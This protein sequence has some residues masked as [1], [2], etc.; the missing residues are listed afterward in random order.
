MATKLIPGVG[1]VDEDRSGQFL[2]P[3]VGSF[4]DPGTYV[5]A[6]S[7]SMT[8][9]SIA[10]VGQASADFVVTINGTP[11]DTVTVTPNDGNQGGTFNPASVFLSPGVLSATFTYTA[12]SSGTK[13]ISLNNDSSLINP[14]P[15][16]VDCTAD[17]QGQITSV[18][19]NGQKGRIDFTFIENPISGVASFVAAATPNG[20]V[21]QG[22]K[23][24][25]LSPS[26]STGF[27]EFD[28]PPGDYDQQSVTLS[29]SAGDTVITSSTAIKVIGVGGSPQAPGNAPPATV[30]GIPTNV[31]A[32]AG[33]GTASVNCTPPSDGGSPITGYQVIA[34]TGQSASSPTLPVAI[35]MPNG[36][37]VTFQIRAVNEVGQGGLSQPSN[38]V[39]PSVP[40]TVPGSPTI[41]TAAAGNGYIDVYFTPPASNGGSPIT[42]YTALLSTGESSVGASSPIRVAASNGTVRTATVTATNLAG[43][44]MPSQASNAVTPSVGITVPDAPTV[45]LVAGVESITATV[46]PPANNGGSP[47]LSYTVTLSTGESKTQAGNPFVFNTLSIAERTATAIATSA[48]GNSAASSVSNAV[49]PIEDV[50][51]PI[52]LFPKGITKIEIRSRG[53]LL[54]MALAMTDSPAP[55]SRTI[56]LG[57]RKST[58]TS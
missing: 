23:P 10:E 24:V 33:N 55:A 19:V 52:D 57:S 32:T 56:T 12:N 35:Q 2:I 4:D 51:V 53:P 28:L 20:A 49:T 1:Y 18:T 47:I 27:V 36:V 29:N 40:I 54:Q 7:L 31:V 22:P 34:S 17:P 42:Y 44:S 50:P 38:S 15:L 14:D 26:T 41:G 37:P 25:T 3:G 46:T 48:I 58:I 16:T 21:T 39:T 13:T 43:T 9:P 5:A 11:G 8:G 6:T 45:T 30:P